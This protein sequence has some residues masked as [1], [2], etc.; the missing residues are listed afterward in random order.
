MSMPWWATCGTRWRREHYQVAKR[1]AKEA[2][3][4]SATSPELLPIPQEGHH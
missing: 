4:V 2:R 1:E 3:E